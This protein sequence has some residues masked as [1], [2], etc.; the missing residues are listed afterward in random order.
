MQLGIGVASYV[1]ITAGG[2]SE[3]YAAVTVHA[4]G[5]AT[6][7]AGTAAHGQGHATSY[8]MI[9]SAATGC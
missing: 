3:E 1:E 7:A 8:A 2:S 5:S 9:V 6:V 4:D